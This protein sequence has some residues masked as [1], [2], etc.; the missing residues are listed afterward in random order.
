MT[1]NTANNTTSLS[2]TILVEK[3]VAHRSSSLPAPNSPSSTEHLSAIRLFNGFYEGFP[4]LVIDLYA[5]TLVFHNYSKSPDSLE[6]ILTQLVAFFRET[7]P[8]IQ[9]IIVKT[10]FS[11]NQDD[12]NGRFLFGNRCDR[13]IVENGVTYAIDLTLNQ[14][15]SF[16]L[17][18]ESLR[19][20]LTENMRDKTVLN[21]FAYTGSLGVAATAGLSKRV[22]HCD[23]NK[24]FLNVAKD[25]YSFKTFP[26]NKV[27][28]I[29]ADFWVT[30]KQLK[31]AKHS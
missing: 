18:T 5:H 12:K 17:D 26:I 8:W 3:S 31:K 23:L 9:A 16:Y 1:K 14:D 28:F 19:L 4:D 10:R 27:D 25:S 20:W 30:V 24:S 7:Y 6:P 22:I 29:A 11:K 2:P 21:T 15:T 13:K